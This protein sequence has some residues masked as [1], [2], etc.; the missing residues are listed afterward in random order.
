MTGLYQTRDGKKDLA[1][2]TI[3]PGVFIGMTEIGG[4]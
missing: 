3:I 2:P 4:N 1:R